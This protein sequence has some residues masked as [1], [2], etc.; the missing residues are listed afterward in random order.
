M[1]GK[2][3][4]KQTYLSANTKY[5][6]VVGDQVP[7]MGSRRL[8]WDGTKM[9]HPIPFILNCSFCKGTGQAYAIDA[10][11]VN[12]DGT[13]ELTNPRLATCM[14]CEG[15]GIQPIEDQE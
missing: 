2:I 8:L 13:S 11:K 12:L 7:V 1:Y 5:V 6:K 4:Q 14:F 15:D 3:N 10:I 9:V